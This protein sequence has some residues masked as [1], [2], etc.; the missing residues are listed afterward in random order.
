MY[1][2]CGERISTPRLQHPEPTH[3]AFSF[4][5]R[6]KCWTLAIFISTTFPLLWHQPLLAASLANQLSLLKPGLISKLHAPPHPPALLCPNA[7]WSTGN[8]FL[9]HSSF[10]SFF[11]SPHLPLLS[12]LLMLPLSQNHRASKTTGSRATGLPAKQPIPDPLLTSTPYCHYTSTTSA[13][14]CP[15]PPH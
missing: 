3:R 14:V 12:P 9:Y 10:L 13:S 15:P 7:G 8:L 6:Q 4:R 11:S 1:S 2:M 5:G